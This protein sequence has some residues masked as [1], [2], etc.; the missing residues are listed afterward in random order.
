MFT[1]EESDTEEIPGSVFYSQMS[2][3]LVKAVQELSEEVTALKAEV[4]ALKGE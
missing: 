4:A 3:V 1:K 2:A